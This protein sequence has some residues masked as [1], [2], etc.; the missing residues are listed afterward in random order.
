MDKKFIYCDARG[1]VSYWEVMN[2]SETDMYIQ[3]FCKNDNG[4]RTFRKDRVLED[5]DNSTDH[6]QR[7][8]Y[9]IEHSPPPKETRAYTY[10][11]RANESE[12]PEICFTGF[13]KIDKER[14][15]KDAELA[16]IFL[17]DSVTKNLEFLCCGDNAGPKKI[18]KSR[19]QGAI[20]LNEKQ[21]IEMLE[22][23]EI[24]E[25]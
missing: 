1:V 4:F 16:G 22:T 19:H 3:G 5:I 14:L 10:N 11:R 7:L 15:S 25:Q 24:P 18:E 23:G 21:F 2:I 9:H 6:E 12:K 20:I 17:R 13:K 8:N